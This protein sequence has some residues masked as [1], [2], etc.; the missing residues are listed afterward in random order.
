MEQVARHLVQTPGRHIYPSSTSGQY[1]LRLRSQLMLPP[2]GTMFVLVPTT[3]LTRAGPP[4]ARPVPI[5]RS[6]AQLPIISHTYLAFV[7]LPEAIFHANHTVRYPVSIRAV[8]S[9]TTP[10]RF[11]GLF[12]VDNCASHGLEKRSSVCR[13]AVS[14]GLMVHY[15]F[16]QSGTEQH[17]PSPEALSTDDNPTPTPGW[18]AP[19]EQ[20][21]HSPAKDAHIM[22]REWAESTLMTGHLVCHASRWMMTFHTAFL[23]KSVAKLALERVQIEVFFVTYWTHITHKPRFARNRVRCPLWAW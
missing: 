7:S 16:G 21:H 6:I 1:D 20:A 5:H 13:Y 17:L 12:T 9:E 19:V 15:P 11:Q 18:M 14:P 22:T 3:P 2:A 23:D 10:A 8:G 4:H